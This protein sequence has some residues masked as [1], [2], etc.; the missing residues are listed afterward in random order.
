MILQSSPLPTG[1]IQAPGVFDGVSALLAERSAFPVLYVTGYGVAAS[2][3][4][5]P[6]AGLIGLG[7]MLD[8]IMVIRA[9]TTKPLIADA[10]T[11][12]GGL[13]NVQHTVRSYARAGVA[14]IQLEDQDSP[15]KCG[16]TQGKRVVNRAEA[17]ARI[18]VACEARSSTTVAIV[19]R[20]DS[21]ATH[22]FSEAMARAEAFRTA[23]ADYVMIDALE[24]SEQ[25]R[26][27][28]SAFRGAAL[29]NLTPA[30]ANFRT[31]QFN[32]GAL[33]EMG[34]AIAIYPALL[35]T[36]AW[37]AMDLS[38]G[39][40]R[41]TGYQPTPRPDALSPHELVGFPAVWADEAR[42]QQRYG[43]DK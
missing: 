5:L 37:D 2:R 27:V 25:I 4:G 43:D 24:T 35:A 18:E 10:D 1:F 8:A 23:G 22:G 19:A 17:I 14:A 41:D 13:L 39:T 9:C 38:L 34:F 29:I 6:D 15:K 11:G 26:A 42:W 33:E 16:H 7:E 20:T 12:Y 21:L 32:A 30:G 3:Y 40:L 31:P 28:G 36:P